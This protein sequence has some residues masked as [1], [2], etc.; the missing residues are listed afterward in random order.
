MALEM[1]N[2]R[3]ELSSDCE[4]NRAGQ[5]SHVR[6]CD[7]LLPHNR[8]FTL[9]FGNKWFDI[10]VGPKKGLL[11]TGARMGPPALMRRAWSRRRATRAEKE[12]W[13]GVAYIAFIAEYGA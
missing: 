11:V 5:D 2:F 13:G 12:E 7:L 3:H 10:S 1:S 9:K 8:Q 6:N 4:G